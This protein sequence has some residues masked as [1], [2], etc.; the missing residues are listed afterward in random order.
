[1]S[2]VR[3]LNSAGLDQTARS[4]S[5]YGHFA[6]NYPG[7]YASVSRVVTGKRLVPAS[8]EDLDYIVGTYNAS[9]A[10]V[11]P[12]SGPTRVLF[13]PG[14]VYALAWR[15]IA[16]TTGRTVYEKVSPLREKVG[17]RVLSQLLTVTDAPLDD[18]QPDARSFDDEGTA[19]RNRAVFERGVLQGF[20]TDRYYAWKLGTE[21]TG[22][23]WRGDVTSRPSPG[24]AHLRIEPGKH[25]LAALLK[26]MGEGVIVGGVLGAHSGNILNGDY[27][28]GLSPGLWVENGRI[29]GQVKDAMVA[30]NVYEDLKRV[31]AVGDRLH[32]GYMGRFPALLLD[33]VQFATRSEGSG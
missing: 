30:G 3:V 33:G 20:H 17:E 10:E 24:L 23:G 6:V 14:C 27:S 15:L 28:I 31:V 22:N 26:E 4:S 12:R 32:P 29:A 18:S 16:A 13:L 9:E 11:R 2:T 5:Y 8:A 25:S 21:P 7:S 1:V 19:C